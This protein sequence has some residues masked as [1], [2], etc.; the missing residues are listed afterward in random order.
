MSKSVLDYHNEIVKCYEDES[1]YNCEGMSRYEFA[2]SHIFNLTTYDSAMDE[3]L[4]KDIIEV[5]EQIIKRDNFNYIKDESNYKKYIIVCNMLE[6]LE[7]IDWGTSIRGAWLEPVF[8]VRTLNNGKLTF[9]AEIL[10]MF[11]EWIG[12]E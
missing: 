9:T 2:S 7:W 12:G 6:K 1:S 8:Y 4:V 11:I 3:I 10:S 5:L